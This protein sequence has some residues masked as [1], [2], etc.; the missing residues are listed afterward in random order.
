MKTMKSIV[1]MLFLAL[2]LSTF[3]QRTNIFL[4]R[5]FWG[6]QPTVETVKQKIK[7]GN[8]PAEANA[9]NFDGVVYATL[10]DAPLKTIIYMISQKGNDV[11]KLTHDGR[12]YAFWA[13][14][15]GNAELVEYLLE[16]GAKTNITDD[17]GNTIINFAAASSHVRC[18]QSC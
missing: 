18:S 12:T 8:N 5:E 15:K 6:T 11:N 3:A 1:V 16:N 14:Y 4:D 10:Q 9:N 7:E 13:A 17:K 2:S